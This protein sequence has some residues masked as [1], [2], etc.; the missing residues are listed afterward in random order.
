MLKKKIQF[1]STSEFKKYCKRVAVAVGYLS[2]KIFGL[3]D[4][5][6]KK[7]AY[8]LGMAFQLTNIVRDFREDLKLDD[9]I[10]LRLN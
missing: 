10:F 5:K 9:V 1:P 8:S 4:H 3:N 2:I 6:G 7:Y